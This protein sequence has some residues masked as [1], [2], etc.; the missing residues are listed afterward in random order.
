MD[1]VW[2]SDYVR[3]MS[4]AKYF[5]YNN[6]LKVN[7]SYRLGERI[8]GIKNW[9]ELPKDFERKQYDN[10]NYKIGFGESK[11]EVT[12]RMLDVINELLDKYKDKRILVVSHSTAL[13]FLLS[14]WCEINYEGPYKYNDK[15][16]SE[17]KWNFCAGFKLIFDE[18]NK[19]VN[20]ENINNI[21]KNVELEVG[22]KLKTLYYKEEKYSENQNG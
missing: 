13:S 15:I 1:V 3:A 5:A 2:A 16:I 4:T 11:K 9:N 10:E 21:N 22:V 8:H 7:V 17:G 14:N 20:I 19:L 6:N 18:N 12:K